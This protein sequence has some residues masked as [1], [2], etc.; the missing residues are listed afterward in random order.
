MVMRNRLRNMEKSK[1]EIREKYQ[2][3]KNYLDRRW[4]HHTMIMM[5]FRQVEQTE[6]RRVWEEEKYRRIRKVD[7][8]EW[9][10]KRRFAGRV[11][12]E[13]R[14]RGIAYGDRELQERARVQERDMYP[15]REHLI[16]GQLPRSE[17]EVKVAE[18]PAKF[19]TYPAVT[20]R[21]ME[22]AAE[23]TNT[24][25]NWEL[26]AR[27]RRTTEGQDGRQTGGEWNKEWQEDQ[28]KYREV[29]DYENETFDFAKLRV[30]DM[31]TCRRRLPP[32]PV[33]VGQTIVLSNIKQKIVEETK[34]YIKEKCDKK[35]FPKQQ[36]VS[37]EVSQGLKSWKKQIQEGE[38]VATATDKSG[39]LA[40]NSRESHILNMQQHMRN[41]PVISWQEKCTLE[42]EMNGHSIQWGRILRLGSSWDS[43]GSHWSRCWSNALRSRFALDPPL[44]G[45]PKSHKSLPAG[46]EDRAHEL[47]PV[48]GAVE[49]SNGPLARLLTEILNMLALV[50]D[51]EIHSLC[52]STEEMAGFFEK[53]NG[54]SET[55]LKLITLSMNVKA[56]FPSVE[57]KVVA[58]VV[59][60]RFLESGLQVEVDTKE[61]A[62]YL[63]IR[64]LERKD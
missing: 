16:Y 48:A 36:N 49:S 45:L 39:D 62:L 32:P 47:R 34:S 64:Y 22:I 33:P 26:L 7:N 35:G 63:A 43:A 3:L 38:V 56:L 21:E 1:G 60:R 30:T 10:W 4:S 40:F 25:I 20:A 58:R 50:M 51:K 24:K 37:K 6:V 5:T 29:Y 15:R 9:R 59:R 14:W 53:L 27:Q 19:A 23:L 61:L 2:K 54:R 13:R 44:S 28:L 8:L 17:Q 31:P 57:A 42:K 46:L 55:F 41:D 52:L 12:D 11:D 18:L